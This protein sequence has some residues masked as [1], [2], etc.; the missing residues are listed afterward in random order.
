MLASLD[1]LKTGSQSA[2]FHEETRSKCL[3][4]YGFASFETCVPVPH[5]KDTGIDPHCTTEFVAQWIWP[6]GLLLR[7]GEEHGRP[8]GVQPQRSVQ[9]LLKMPVPVFLCIVVEAPGLR[10]INT[11]YHQRQRNF[12]STTQILLSLPGSMLTIAPEHAS[13][14]EQLYPE[15]PPGP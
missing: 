7:S 8:L 12:C 5:P 4:H 14:S 13:R 1:G 15:R 3:A 10:R 2:N 11:P 9:R 6:V